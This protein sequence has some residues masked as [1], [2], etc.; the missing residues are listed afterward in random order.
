MKRILAFTI[1]GSFLIIAFGITPVTRHLRCADSKDLIT[2][3]MMSGQAWAAA[4]ITSNLE[5][6]E[7]F[8]NTNSREWTII[9]FDTED[10]DKA[11]VLYRGNNW[12]FPGEMGI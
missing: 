5:V 8:I 2:K 1:L 6:W 3:T 7:L 11:C 10:P 9:G 4:F 12:T